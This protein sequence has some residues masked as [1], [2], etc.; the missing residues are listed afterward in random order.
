M[1]VLART[2]QIGQALAGRV[3]NEC[4]LMHATVFDTVGR[5]LIARIYQL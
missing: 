1:L 2:L 5:V 4:V 3:A